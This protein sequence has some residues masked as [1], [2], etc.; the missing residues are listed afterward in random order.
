MEK[1]NKSLDIFLIVAT[2]CVLL[3]AI[4]G[5]MHYLYKQNQ[6]MKYKHEAILD[7]VHELQNRQL[8]HQDIAIIVKYVQ[9]EDKCKGKSGTVSYI[10]DSRETQN[11]WN[12]PLDRMTCV[13]P[14]SDVYKYED[15]IK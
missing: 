12:I 8:S 5:G 1:Q 2:L 14:K 4:A 7:K 6:E 13:V 15:L 3:I 10:V 11:F 9:F